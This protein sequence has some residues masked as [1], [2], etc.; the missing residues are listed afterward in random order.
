[1]LPVEADAEDLAEGTALVSQAAR[2]IQDDAPTV[3]ES[4]AVT[5]TGALAEPSP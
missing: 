2:N 1:M 4:M 5:R 3:H